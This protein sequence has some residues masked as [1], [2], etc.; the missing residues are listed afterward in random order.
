MTPTED[1][2]TGQLT[3]R[4]LRELRETGQTPTITPDQ[5]AAAAAA[6]EAAAL[7]EITP[8]QRS[9]F[10]PPVEAEPVVEVPA[11]VDAPPVV[12]NAP[13]EAAPVASHARRSRR[14]ARAE[15]AHTETVET[16]EPLEPSAAEVA[17]PVDAPSVPDAT[18][19]AAEVPSFAPPID[20]APQPAVSEP[21]V[22][23]HD[24]VVEAELIDT[25]L[26]PAPRRDYSTPVS[27][28]LIDVP[29]PGVEEASEDERP[30]LRPEF[31]AAVFGG[32]AP[33]A[34]A[35]SFDDL[36]TQDHDMSGST[37]TG[38]ALIM[39]DGSNLPPLTAPVTATGEVLVTGTFALP[40]LGSQGHAPGVADGK[41]VDAVL[42]DGEL[43]AASSPTPIAAT[44]AVS[45]AK[46]PG[47]IIKAPVPEKG[48]KLVLT[49]AITAGVLAVLLVGSI[50][51]YVASQGGL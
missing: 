13:V 46:A 22:L 32:A 50:I 7:D 8:P 12:Q 29:A 24:E 26:P 9:V 17:E 30:I 21:L 15:R 23:S 2:P 1:N 33:A 31:G 18:E 48:N 35:P 42:I 25:T 43:P 3:R 34:A 6:A 4:Q 37:S 41:D 27:T 5:A 10:E 19:G 14:A 51:F 39:P 36:L 20:M 38:S 49:I 45:Q 16:N 28:P 47:E 40:E 44:A 11:V